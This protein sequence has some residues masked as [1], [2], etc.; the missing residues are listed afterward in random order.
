M[1][2]LSSEDSF[3]KTAECVA[4][5]KSYEAIANGIDEWRLELER[6]LKLPKGS[7]Y[8]WKPGQEER[9]DRSDERL[10]NLE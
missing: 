7:L 10:D 6:A 3:D 2:S 8:Y 4:A 9:L 5:C 1:I